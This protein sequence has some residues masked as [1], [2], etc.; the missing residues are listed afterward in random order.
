ML[1]VI[2]C[3]GAWNELKWRHHS[4]GLLQAYLPNED[5]LRIHIWNRRLKLRDSGAM[6]N[7]RFDLQS[8]V[9]VGSLTHTRLILTPDEENG[10]HNVWDIPGAS[11]GSNE[12]LRLHDQ[13]SVKGSRVNMA[14]I[15]TRRFEEG[16]SY[17]VRKWEFHWARQ[18]ESDDE[19]TVTLVR[20]HNKE[21]DRPASLVYP[22]GHQPTHAFTERPEP[23]L[24]LSLVH[25][26][27][28]HL[29]K[30]T[31]LSRR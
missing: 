25:D 1:D 11:Q 23:A 3:L 31:G 20:L 21:T 6:H 19:L 29:E 2:K 13:T 7:H 5:G 12:T 15:D 30:L 4:T 26:A 18:E 9:L 22:Y 10:T 17:T 8:H 14:M 28:L 16:D 24:M 27:R